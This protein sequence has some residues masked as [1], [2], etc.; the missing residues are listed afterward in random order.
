MIARLL[1]D[2]AH[3]FF[4]LISKLT[5]Y[6]E[7]FSESGTHLVSAQIGEAILFGK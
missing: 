3:V 5:Y 6:S 2:T 1:E 7:Y 4:N